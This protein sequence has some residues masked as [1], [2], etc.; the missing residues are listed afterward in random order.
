MKKHNYKSALI[1]TDPTHSR[2]VK[3]LCSLIPEGDVEQKFHIV[4]SGVE[5]WNKEC[6]WCNKRSRELVKGETLRIIYTLIFSGSLRYG[7]MDGYFK[8]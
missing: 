8:L 1:V 4:S 6:Y 3:L 5:W 2:R 7:N